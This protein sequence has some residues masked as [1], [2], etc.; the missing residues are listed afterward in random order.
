MPAAMILPSVLGASQA[1]VKA[2]LLPE[3]SPRLKFAIK[4]SLSL[5]LAYLIPLSMG[6]SQP[7]T[8]AIT[9]MLIAAAGTIGESLANGAVR[10]VGTVIGACIGLALIALFPQERLLYLAALSCVLAC[11]IYLYYVYRGDSTVFMLTAMVT[12]MVFLHGPQNAFLYGVERT[13]MTLFG[14]AVYTVIA[15]FVWPVK[16]KSGL[17]AD[18]AGLGRAQAELFEALTGGSGE[19]KPLLA[20]M[21]EAQE[22]LD[23]ST[24]GGTI[25]E[26]NRLRAI[27]VYYRKIGAVLHALSEQ[28]FMRGKPDLAEHIEGYDTLCREIGV[29]FER[30]VDACRGVLSPELP[31]G[32][33]VP[34]IRDGRSLSHLQRSEAVAFAQL[35]AKLHQ[36]L[37]DL[38]LALHFGGRNGSMKS[39]EKAGGEVPWFIRPDPEAFKA[40]LKLTLVFWAATAFWIVFNPPGGFLIVTLATVLGLLVTNTPLNPKVLMLLLTM[41]FSFAALTYVFVLPHLVDGWELA[42]F[43][44]VYALIGFYLINPKMTLFFMIGLFLLNI[45]NQM[46]YNFAFL[47]NELLVFYLFLTILLFFNDFPFSEKPEHLFVKGRERFFNHAA[48]LA[49]MMQADGPKGAWQRCAAAYRRYRMARCAGQLAQWG[50]LIDTRYFR[51]NDKVCIETFA[52][53]C[54][55]LAYRLQTLWDEEN[56]ANPLLQSFSPAQ[57]SAALA[58]VLGRMGGPETDAAFLAD[59]G[60]RAALVQKAEAGLQRLQEDV[61]AAAY[62]IEEIIEFYY[63]I[64]LRRN[65]WEALAACGDAMRAIDWKNLR[66]KR[67]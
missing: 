64:A 52:A 34:R 47:L 30:S 56:P 2:W 31:P 53:A 14:I 6:W 27:G 28:P 16:T 11:I 55:S 63:A 13:Y 66:E 26:E 58:K 18:T 15:V 49:E 45:Q 40:T 51:A 67:F 57:R 25:G 5:T 21:E 7:N 12:M 17:A 23:R 54:A 36:N 37:R 24:R 44:F 20:P 60:E 3:L 48:A 9:V 39:P 19:A 22:K 29:M 50:G 62:R 10:I 38:L 1:F 8:A 46:Q 59:Q 42:I 65:V 35:L 41:G 33:Y 4:V 43:I 32:G 61:D